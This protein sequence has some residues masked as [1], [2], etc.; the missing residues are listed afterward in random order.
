MARDIPFRIVE[1]KEVYSGKAFQVRDDRLEAGGRRFRRQVVVHPGAAAI[2]PLLPDG[3]VLMVRQYRHGLAERLLEIPAGTL[4]P[5][6]PPEACARREIEEEAGYRAGR[7]VP[8]GPFYPT[9][10]ISTEVIHLFAATDLVQAEAH[11]EP[12]ED[13]EVETHAL[14]EVVRMIVD[15]RIRDGKTIAAT[16]MWLWGKGER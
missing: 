13:I 16:A 10:G 5:G 15:G 1:S 9:P 7:L 6:E 4:E 11:P 3:R 2:L 14:D 12:D 8:L